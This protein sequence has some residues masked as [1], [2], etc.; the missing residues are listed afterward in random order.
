MLQTTTTPAN[1]ASDAQRFPPAAPCAREVLAT[2][3]SL[4]ARLFDLRASLCG[5]EPPKRPT[6]PSETKEPLPAALAMANSALM[7]AADLVGD[8]EQMLIG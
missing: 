6:K 8:L 2:A 1:N 3:E 5:E 4:R 7:R